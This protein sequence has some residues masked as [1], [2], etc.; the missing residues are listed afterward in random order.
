MALGAR[1]S[2]ATTYLLR[3][4]CPCVPDLPWGRVVAAVAFAFAA[5]G[6]GQA[7]QWGG[8]LA[9]VWATGMTTRHVLCMHWH[10]H[11]VSGVCNVVAS[12]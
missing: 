1:R 10:A 12:M 6:P 2:V 5:C 11:R 7:C 9:V 4:G 3:Y 8:A